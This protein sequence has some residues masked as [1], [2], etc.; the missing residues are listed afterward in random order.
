VANGLNHPIVCLGLGTLALAGSSFACAALA[1]RF[2]AGLP[3]RPTRRQLLAGL[4]ACVPLIGLAFALTIT[5]RTYAATTAGSGAALTYLLIVPAALLGKAPPRSAWTLWRRAVLPFC[6]ATAATWVIIGTAGTFRPLDGQFLI[7]LFVL[8]TWL[9][10]VESKTAR[11]WVGPALT[12][13]PAGSTAEAPR[14]DAPSSV[15]VP[16]KAATKARTT[17]VLLSV[18]AASL[19]AAAALMVAAGR[20]SWAEY[21]VPLLG[22]LTCAGPVLIASTDV[23]GRAA[24]WLGGLGYATMAAACLVPG[25]AGFVQ[26]GVAAPPLYGPDGAFLALAAAV[27]LALG[28][29]GLM[30]SRTARRLLAGTW[31]IWLTWILLSVLLALYP[32]AQPSPSDPSVWDLP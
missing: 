11:A 22:G 24:D 23:A 25:I 15:A 28:G 18:A 7:T 26:P 10:S 19:T 5:G 4:A 8:G 9:F 14:P 1:R 32:V 16:A 13:A 27:L 17:T 30:T 3:E 20:G 21:L 29:E 2:L 6:L 12:T 31:A